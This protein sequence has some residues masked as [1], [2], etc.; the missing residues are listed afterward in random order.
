MIGSA[1]LVIS[2]VKLQ[3]GFGSCRYALRKV[4]L[5]KAFHNTW[6]DV[7]VRGH[8]DLTVAVVFHMKYMK[9]VQQQQPSQHVFYHYVKRLISYILEGI[10]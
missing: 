1:D 2:C 10:C 8:L 6:R 3:N 5:V 4:L 9:V 7:L